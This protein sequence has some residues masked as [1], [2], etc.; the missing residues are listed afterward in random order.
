MNKLKGKKP[1]PRQAPA[2]APAASRG[3]PP[4]LQP[5]NIQTRTV[6]SK[7][8]RVNAP[9]NVSI[10]PK[11]NGEE[12]YN[13]SSSLASPNTIRNVRLD[14]VDSRSGT[15]HIQTSP[16]REFMSDRDRAFELISPKGNNNTIKEQS[17]DGGSKPSSLKRLQSQKSQTLGNGSQQHIA[18]P[19]LKNNVVI[20]EVEEV[21]KPSSKPTS[22]KRLQSQKSQTL[23]GSQQNVK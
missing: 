19:K 20:E 12:N 16:M 6:V 10:Q 18:S 8:R 13:S 17:N 22:L 11:Q 9:S 21:S 14:F 3:A 4:S 7:V 23:G 2:P 15:M 1:A 5:N